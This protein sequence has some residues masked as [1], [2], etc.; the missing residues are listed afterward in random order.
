MKKA[1]KVFYVDIVVD[2][3]LAVMDMPGYSHR[4][5]TNEQRYIETHF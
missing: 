1:D 4:I 5:P 3:E 2:Q